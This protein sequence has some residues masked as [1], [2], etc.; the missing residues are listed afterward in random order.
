MGTIIGS[1]WLL[2]GIILLNYYMIFQNV[3]GLTLSLCQLVLLLLY[4]GGQDNS[5]KD[6]RKKKD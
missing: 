1:L 4:P 2:Y 6:A 3:V 5:D